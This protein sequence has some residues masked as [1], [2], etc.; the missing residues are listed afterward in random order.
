M[1]QLVVAGIVSIARGM[2]KRTVAEFVGD[3]ETAQLLR[4]IGVDQAQ[5]YPIGVPRQVPKVLQPIGAG[6]S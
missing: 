5:G 1:N 4:T 6:L 2:G 3:E